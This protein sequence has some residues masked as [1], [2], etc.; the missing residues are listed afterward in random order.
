[1]VV[2]SITD[3]NGCT[4]V[5][6]PFIVTVSLPNADYSFVASSN[7]Q[8]AAASWTCPSVKVNFSDASQSIGNVTGWNWTFGDGNFS[9][10]QNPENLYVFAGVYDLTFTITDQYGC[11]SDSITA[12]FLNIDGPQGNLVV[13]SDPNAT[14]NQTFTFEMTDTYN[15]ASWTWVMG[16][17]TTFE[18]GNPIEYT[19]KEPGTY[20]GVLLIRDDKDCEVPL[21]FT[22]TSTNNG[23]TAD[24]IF[25]PTPTADLGQLVIFTDQS[26]SPSLGGIVLWDWEFSDGYTTS[27]ATGEDIKHVFSQTDSLYITLS[28]QDAEGCW[29]EITKVIYIENNLYIPNIFSPNGDDKNEKWYIPGTPFKSY[30]ILIYNRWGSLMF[31]ESKQTDGSEGGLHVSWDGRNNGKGLCSDGTYYFILKGTLVDDTVVEHTGFI[32]LVDGKD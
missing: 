21:P 23:I 15:V 22:V 30:D 16:D 4:A 24:F 26:S 19:Y 3:K 17:T 12:P 6:D 8:G 10:D 32:T 11:T 5:S 31:E 20:T 9:V 2:L 28:V 25:T 13:T 14:C 29:D 18:G 7:S 1:A 27:N